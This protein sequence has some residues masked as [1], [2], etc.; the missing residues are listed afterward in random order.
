MHLHGEYMSA[1]RAHAGIIFG[2]QQRF[3]VGE[4]MRWLLRI[5]VLRSDEEMQNNYEFLAHGKGPQKGDE[6]EPLRNY[7]LLQI[8]AKRR[9]PKPLM[10]YDYSREHMEQK[11]RQLPQARERIM[12]IAR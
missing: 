6:S 9:N 8:M 12:G 7:N 11:G 3:S 2:D 1:G 10:R 5:L 4:Q